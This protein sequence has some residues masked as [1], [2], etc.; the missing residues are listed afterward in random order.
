MFSGSRHRRLFLCGGLAQ[1]LGGKVP[2]LSSLM[3][4]NG[5]AAE[6]ASRH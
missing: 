4:L 3:V 2:S 6:N 1:H 5:H